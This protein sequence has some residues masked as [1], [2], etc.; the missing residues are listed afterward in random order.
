VNSAP[1][2]LKNLALKNAG[3]ITHAALSVSN[4]EQ[5]KNEERL[6]LPPQPTI[7]E[8]RKLPQRGLWRSPRRE[9]FC[10]IIDI[11]KDF[12]DT[13]KWTALSNSK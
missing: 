1:F 2:Q 8:H 11:K 3:V 9:R 4:T 5:R 10:G 13:K 12:S 6:A 7:V